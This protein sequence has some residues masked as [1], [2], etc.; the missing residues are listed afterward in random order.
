MQKILRDVR[1][2]VEKAIIMRNDGQNNKEIAAALGL[3]RSTFLDIVS[4]D[5][6]NKHCPELLEQFYCLEKLANTKSE[7]MRLKVLQVIGARQTGKTM[8][9]IAK[10]L[11]M[12]T[13][14]LFGITSERNIRRHC[15]DLMT[16]LR[17]S[18]NKDGFGKNKSNRPFSFLFLK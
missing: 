5:S 9:D 17:E 1:G 12:S 16:P 7:Y 18:L 14:A 3:A 10:M 8:D 13:S 4:K 11:K 6:I 2:I 15:P